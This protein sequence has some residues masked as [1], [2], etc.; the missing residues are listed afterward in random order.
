MTAKFWPPTRR[1]ICS[2]SWPGSSQIV[3]EI[4]APAEELRELL[5]QMPEVEHFDV[6]A[7]RRR[8]PACALTPRDGYDLRPAIF[9]LARER[10]WMLRELTRS[11]HSLEDIYVQVTKPNEEEEKLMR[12]FMTLLRRELAAFFFSINGLRH[13]R[14][15][16]A[17]DRPELCGADDESRQRSVADAGDGDVLPHLF[18]LADCAAGRAGHH[19]AAVRAGKIQPAR[20]K[21]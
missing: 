7:M 15:G 21:R 13:H 12:I 4:A 11:R 16:D 10:G 17:A 8:I 1:K 19:H 5:A 3:A 20:L 9:L 18:F 14:G 2:G 6:S